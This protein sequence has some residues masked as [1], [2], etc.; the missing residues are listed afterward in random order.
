MMGGWRKE[1]GG[2]REG[3]GKGEGK[4]RKKAETLHAHSRVQKP[5]Q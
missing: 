5:I 4:I 3:R 1:R 2:E